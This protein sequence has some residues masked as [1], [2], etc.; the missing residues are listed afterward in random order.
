[1]EAES[2]R[3]QCD[4]STG[5]Y[6]PQIAR[7]HGQTIVRDPEVAIWT[8]GNVIDARS[9]Y[10]HSKFQR[11]RHDCSC[12]CC[13]GSIKSVKYTKENDSMSERVPD[14]ALDLFEKPA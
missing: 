3:R 4:R 6:A 12:K 2:S 5:S 11:N 8:C 10:R 9:G 13:Y 1:M 7:I 14:N